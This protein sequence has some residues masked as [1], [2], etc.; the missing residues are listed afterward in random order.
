MLQKILTFLKSSFSEPTGEGSASRVIAGSVTGAV[1]V[2]VSY[3]VV[4]NNTLP[5][6]TS[7]SLFL[8]A[9]SGAYAGNKISKAFKNDSPK[10]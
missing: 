3:L 7:A 9:G 1:L 5:D 4:K 2:W 6:L 8:A 10:E